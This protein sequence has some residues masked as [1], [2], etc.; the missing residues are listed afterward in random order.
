[1]NHVTQVG[2]VDAHPKGI[3]RNDDFQLVPH[4]LI[5]HQFALVGHQAGMVGSDANLDLFRDLFDQGFAAF[6]SRCVDNPGP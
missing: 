5:L 4:E 3:G 2:F 1:M 6:T